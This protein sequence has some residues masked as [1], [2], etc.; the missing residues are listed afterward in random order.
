MSPP[1]SI[2]I[3]Y[4]A[5]KLHKAKYS[6]SNIRKVFFANF[7]K[8]I[9]KKKRGIVISECKTHKVFFLKVQYKHNFQIFLFFLLLFM[10]YLQFIFCLDSIVFLPK[11]IYKEKKYCDMRKQNS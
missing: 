9:S 1:C 2:S 10:L 7:L 6:E 4:I 3:Y 5:N 11:I 8:K